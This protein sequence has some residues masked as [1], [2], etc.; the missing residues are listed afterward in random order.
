[1]IFKQS[2]MSSILKSNSEDCMIFDEVV[3]RYKFGLSFRCT[4]YPGKAMQTAM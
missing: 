3:D 2:H 4:L 1:V